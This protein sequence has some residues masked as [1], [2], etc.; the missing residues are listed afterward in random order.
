MYD[1][2]LPKRDHGVGPCQCVDRE[3]IREVEELLLD[4]V[5]DSRF[6]TD[7]LRYLQRTLGELLPEKK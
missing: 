7:D 5:E 6:F 4:L 1:L 2:L 3:D